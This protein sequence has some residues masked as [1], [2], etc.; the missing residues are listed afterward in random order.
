MVYKVS[1]RTAGAPQRNPV[2]EKKKKKKD[3]QTLRDSASQTGAICNGDPMPP[4]GMSEDSYSVFIYIKQ[5][6]L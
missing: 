6:N 2:S 4:F 5:I 1:S 3:S